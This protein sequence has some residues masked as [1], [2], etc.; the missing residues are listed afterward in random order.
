MADNQN[1]N[2]DQLVEEIR[3]LDMHAATADDNG[4]PSGR[5]RVPRMVCSA[6]CPNSRPANRYRAPSHH[7][8]PWLA[9]VLTRRANANAHRMH[10]H[11]SVWSM[12]IQEMRTGTLCPLFSSSCAQASNKS[13]APLAFKQ[14]PL[15][16]VGDK[17]AANEKP[18]K[19]ESSNDS[20]QSSDS[21]Q[22][23]HETDDEEKALA[24][25]QGK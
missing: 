16:F 12:G 11:P 21:D 13:F 23:A 7:I 22:K 25:P 18:P 8:A 3:A 10:P 5:P 2:S 17:T 14:K 20:G 6:S 4:V 9:R 24:K 19:R 15:V 1:A